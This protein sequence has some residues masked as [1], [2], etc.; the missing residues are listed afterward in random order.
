[1]MLQKM[2]EQR[3]ISGI[4]SGILYKN[5][6]GKYS[7][8]CPVS[9]VPSIKGDTDALD[10]EVTSND[11]KTQIDGMKTLSKAEF[12][13]F[14]H[15]DNMR[16]FKKLEGKVVDLI[17]FSNDRTG[18]KVSG[19][20]SYKIGEQENGNPTKATITVTPKAYYGTVDDVKPLFQATALFASEVPAIV[21]VDPDTKKFELEIEMDPIDATITAT[22]EATGIATVTVTD[23][24]VVI[25]GV[26]EGSTVV[27]LKSSHKDCASWETTIVVDVPKITAGS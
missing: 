6:S 11:T 25:T 17:L 2:A 15:R 13:V 5:S 22:S 10:I 27:L 7:I 16:L 1:M 14:H 12:E 19:S 24:K 23:K 3:A 26:A 18:E 9:K 21:T 4:G 8:L 20:L